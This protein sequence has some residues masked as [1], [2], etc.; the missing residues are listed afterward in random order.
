MKF[1][2]ERHFSA[3]RPVAQWSVT[4]PPGVLVSYPQD[5]QDKLDALMQFAKIKVV[6]NS[7]SNVG[8]T[9]RDSTASSAASDHQYLKQLAGEVW[10][11][12]C[13]PA[14]HKLNA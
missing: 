5:L 8:V 9:V 3:T 2:P 4:I 11:K 12:V 6:V 7:A 14:G 1:S 10:E 13:S